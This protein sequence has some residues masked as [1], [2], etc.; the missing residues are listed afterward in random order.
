MQIHFSKPEISY[1]I[2]VFFSQSTDQV[3]LYHSSLE[4]SA[5]IPSAVITEAHSYFFDRNSRTRLAF[6]DKSL[7]IVTSNEAVTANKFGCQVFK[8]YKYM[9]KALKNV[10]NCIK[11]SP[12]V[13]TMYMVK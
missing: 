6:L 4:T 9:Y 7:H 8:M 3:S 11:I 1:N 2:S 5:K 10:N 13:K 12:S